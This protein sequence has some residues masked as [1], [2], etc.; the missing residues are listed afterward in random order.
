M[1][2]DYAVRFKHGDS[3]LFH[4]NGTENGGGGKKERK[5]GN[6]NP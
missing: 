3:Q 1:Y 4:I 6:I 5:Q 2:I